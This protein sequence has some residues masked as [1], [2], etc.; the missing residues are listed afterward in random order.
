MKDTLLRFILNLRRPTKAANIKLLKQHGE[1][2]NSLLIRE[3]TLSDIPALAA[4]HVKAWNQTY[5][6]VK[7]PPTFEIRQYQ[8]EEQFKQTDQSWFCLIV[9]NSQKELI[10]FAKGQRYTDKLKFE[11]ELNKLYLLQDYQRLGIGR[12]LVGNVIQH[13]LAKGINSMVLFS[14]PSNPSIRFYEAIKG[15]RIY[16]EDGKFHGAY[17]WNDLAAIVPIFPKE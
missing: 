9:E 5:P 7:R 2:L 14:E 4:L 3:V 1:A 11:G 10:G 16:A 15:E 8:W 12:R 13:F 17:G 6:F